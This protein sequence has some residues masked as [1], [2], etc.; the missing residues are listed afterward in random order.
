M[1]GIK[2]DASLLKYKQHNPI[3]S[4]ISQIY[5]PDEIPCEI[6]SIKVDMDAISKSNNIVE[7]GLVRSVGDVYLG[8][9][10]LGWITIIN[11][12]GSTFEELDILK[13][14]CAQLITYEFNSLR[15][16]P[17]EYDKG[18][19]SCFSGSKTEEIKPVEYVLDLKEGEKFF[20][21]NDK[22]LEN[23]AYET[24]K[25]SDRAVLIICSTATGNTNCLKP[26]KH[27]NHC[28]TINLASSKCWSEDFFDDFILAED[29]DLNQKEE[30]LNKIKDFMQEKNI[31][32]DGLINVAD[33]SVQMTAFLA[34]HLDCL[35][36][37]FEVAQR[38]QN[39]YEFR[40][41]SEQLGIVTP[42]YRLL[43]SNERSRHVAFL[44]L[45]QSL[46]IKPMDEFEKHLMVMLTGLNSAFILKNPIG[47]GKGILLF[48]FF[49]SQ[50]F[51]CFQVYF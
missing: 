42:R 17:I 18:I 20:Y 10:D 33:E 7:V 1:L 45:S 9:F 27:L 47:C 43:K 5:F 2:L 16:S 50:F 37:P 39:K 46:E 24:D 32:F 4:C 44:G 6:Q 35:G 48:S 36:I 14:A 38:I 11:K 12:Y 25:Y 13:N 19:E 31:R 41:Y 30:T 28:Y 26:V 15:K 22:L 29:K 49:I 3:N 51:R 40:Q 8:D 23:P 34:E 21:L